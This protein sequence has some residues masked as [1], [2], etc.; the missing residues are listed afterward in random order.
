MGENKCEQRYGPDQGREGYYD[1]SS[2]P[3][4]VQEGI[5]QAGQGLNDPGPALKCVSDAMSSASTPK[6][7]FTTRQASAADGVDQANP[8]YCHRVRFAWGLR[9]RAD[10]LMVPTGPKGFWSV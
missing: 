3:N 7:T 2:R 6:R 4:Q 8:H 9:R 1:A 5:H 10:A